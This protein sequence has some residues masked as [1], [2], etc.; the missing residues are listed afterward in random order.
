MQHLS[1]ANPSLYCRLQSV[2]VG[3]R[4]SYSSAGGGAANNS[5]AAAA[6][7]G[8]NTPTRINTR[9]WLQGLKMTRTKKFC[10]NRSPRLSPRGSPTLPRANFKGQNFLD[11]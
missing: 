11:V 6:A 3:R 2:S 7:S 4:R 10:F 8:S 5:G 9:Y 1:L